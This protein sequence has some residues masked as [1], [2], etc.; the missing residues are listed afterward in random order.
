MVEQTKSK[1]NPN[2]R[3][4]WVIFC[5]KFENYLNFFNLSFWWLDSNLNSELP[6]YVLRMGECN[7]SP[8]RLIFLDL[9]QLGFREK[10]FTVKIYSARINFQT[11]NFYSVVAVAANH[12]QRQKDYCLIRYLPKKKKNNRIRNPQK[13]LSFTEISPFKKHG[14]DLMLSH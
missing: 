7:R 4:F 6:Q 14:T 11:I 12:Q 13:G 5:H 10:L 9:A 3:S 2:E 1:G 8:K